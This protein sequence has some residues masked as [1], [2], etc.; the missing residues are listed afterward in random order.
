M[1]YKELN[2][3]NHE[4]K[5]FDFNLGQ[6]QYF[7]CPD[8]SHELLYVREN[9]EKAWKSELGLLRKISTARKGVFHFLMKL[10]ERKIVEK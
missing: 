2:E 6:E 8:C 4:Q 10:E 9:L 5:K 1:S 7:F 3:C